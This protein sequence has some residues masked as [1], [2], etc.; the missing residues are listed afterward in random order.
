M[1]FNGAATISLVTRDPVLGSVAPTLSSIANSS[2]IRITVGY[3]DFAII[4][5]GGTY[6]AVTTHEAGEEVKFVLI[7]SEEAAMT[8]AFKSPLKIIRGGQAVGIWSLSL[9][10]GAR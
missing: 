6:C 5:H 9:S 1:G 7:V 2:L 3:Q 10:L 4:C 8:L